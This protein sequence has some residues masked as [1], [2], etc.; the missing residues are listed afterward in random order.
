VRARNRSKSAIWCLALAIVSVGDLAEGADSPGPADDLLRLVPP[1]ATVVVTVEGLRDHARIIGDSRLAVDLQRLP[2]VR[3]WLESERSRSLKRSCSEIEAMLGVKLA[4]LR[5][6]LLGDAV[7]LV[8]RMDPAAP[9]DPSQ[10]RGLLLLRA[11]DPALLERLIEA[12]N[13]TQRASGELE[14]VSDRR[15][16][17]TTYHVREFPAGSGRPPEW[18]ISDPDGTFAFSNSEAM[19]QG[20]I[21]RKVGSRAGAG[22]G[23]GLGELPK[24][25][26][27]RR[28]L[29]DRPLARLYVDP[30]AIERLLTAAPR[31]AKPTDAR[32]RAMLERHLAAVDYAGAALVCRAD[33]IVVQA[34]ETIDPSRMDG[35]LRHWAS[36]ARPFRPELRRIPRTALALASVH[37]DLAAIRDALYQVVSEA[38]HQRL[39]NFETLLK[40]LLLGQDLPSRILPAL[41]P[42]VIGYLDA[43]ADPAAEN[44]EGN[45]S[46]PARGGLFPAVMVVDIR[47]DTAGSSPDSRR[48]GPAAVAVSDAFEN[49]LRTL[50]ALL[51]LDEK[52]GQGRARIAT[53]EAAGAS[54]TTL[55]T[56]I[57]FAYAIDRPGGRLVLGTSAPAVA[58]YLESASDPEAGVRFRDLQAAAFPGFATFICIDLDA[59]TRLGSQYRARLARNLAARQNRPA[60]EVE[61]DLEHVLALAGLFR[62]AFIASRIEPDATAIHRTFGV[63]LKDSQGP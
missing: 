24:V 54:V 61:G 30:R 49:A 29:P 34:V 2:V 40:G 28:R 20:V 62:A 14:R 44:G 7:V 23:P 36:D 52:R 18:Y 58:R 10:A 51:A 38:D 8:L 4:D 16:A 57:P 5:D 42:G 48:R 1:D 32:V 60:A 33:A 6:D 41:G 27:V 21:D 45:G 13:T 26:A 12:F 25:V 63:I 11:R 43:P 9:T 46:P 59:V 37:I 53:F 19:I 3:S 35:W 39:Q 31:A 55:S 47:G 56:P 22:A 17:E 15:R 50:L